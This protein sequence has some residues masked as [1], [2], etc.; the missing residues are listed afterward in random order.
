MKIAINIAFVLLFLLALLFLVDSF[1]HD[2]RKVLFAAAGFGIGIGIGLMRLWNNLVALQQL[3]RP[4]S[5]GVVPGS[6]PPPEDRR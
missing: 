2:L 5:P 6:K 1:Q 3:S 4:T